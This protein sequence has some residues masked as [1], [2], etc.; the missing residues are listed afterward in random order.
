MF[1]DYKTIADL[2]FSSLTNFLH[3]YIS[4]HPNCEIIPA[5]EGVYIDHDFGDKPKLAP[6]VASAG[7]WS[8]MVERQQ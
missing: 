7:L 1:Y 5:E 3:D 6:Y 2:G 8:K 4:T